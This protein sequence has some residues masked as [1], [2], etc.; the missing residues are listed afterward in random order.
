MRASKDTPPYFSGWANTCGRKSKQQAQH[1]NFE[2]NQTKPNHHQPVH[3]ELHHNPSLQSLEQSLHSLPSLYCS[4]NIGSQ[5][6]VFKATTCSGF[7]STFLLSST[8][9]ATA[10]TTC[11]DLTVLKVLRPVVP[12]AR[13]CFLSIFFFWHWLLGLLGSL[14]P[15]VCCSPFY[16]LAMPDNQST[17][18]MSNHGY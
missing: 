17:V 8:Y 6:C 2:L 11:L 10:T 12:P 15:L 7:N 13:L 1:L 4:L 18:C 9:Q 16:H 14:G 3:L 5:S